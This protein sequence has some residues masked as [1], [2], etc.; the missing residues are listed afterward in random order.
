M[1]VHRRKEKRN[2]RIQE[3]FKQKRK[4]KRGEKKPFN[5]LIKIIRMECVHTT[6]ASSFE[7]KR[8]NEKKRKKGITVMEISKV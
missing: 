1:F 2:A 6:E 3:M 7:M 4:K 5:I 8:K